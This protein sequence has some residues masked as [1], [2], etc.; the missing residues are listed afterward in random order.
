MS[1]LAYRTLRENV[2]DMIR[3]KILNHE[4][5]PGQRI[6]EMELANEFHTSRGPIREAL[7]QLEN[8]GI[9]EYTRNV[10]C[11]VRTFSFWDSYEVYLLRTSYELVSVRFLKGRIPDRTLSD[12]EE[13][14]DGMKR[15]PSEGFEKIFEYDNNFHEELVRMS[16]LPRLHKAWKEQYYGNL[17]AGYHEILDKE[18]MMAQQ[19][20]LH[21][22][23]FDVCVTGDCEQI[24]KTIRQHYW[25]TISRMMREQN[26][27]NEALEIS[28]KQ[29]LS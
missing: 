2:V 13:I 21:K 22:E 16:G 24:C 12:L 5:K 8:E 14:L 15:I 25:R 3:A 23:I 29:V 1:V 19:Y 6:V 28:W 26:I 7:R 18:Q 4:I 27:R 9:I 17:L 10:G 20:F 11:S